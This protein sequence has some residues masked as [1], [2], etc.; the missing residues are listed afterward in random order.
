MNLNLCNSND[1]V[2]FWGVP[3][4]VNQGGFADLDNL[5]GQSLGSSIDP[6]LQAGC[7]CYKPGNFSGV[8]L[9]TNVGISALR[10]GIS[11][12][13]P[14]DRAGGWIA[15]EAN[16]KGFVPNRLSSE[17]IAE[18]PSTNLIMGMMVYKIT[19][20][21]LQININGLLDGW[22]CFNTQDCD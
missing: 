7:K 20:N 3:L 6:S 15:L 12:N 21:C 18:I 4:I 8:G 9:P 2:D 16:S 19:L 10:E 5:S 17:Q 11:P 22:K 13:W 14:M 1:C